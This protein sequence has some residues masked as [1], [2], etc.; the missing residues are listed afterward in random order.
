MLLFKKV[1]YELRQNKTK[2]ATK[3]VA[4]VLQK[5]FEPTVF[6][7]NLTISSQNLFNWLQR[8]IQLVFTSLR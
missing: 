8:Q 5:L 3:K 2:I 6:S 1:S 4:I 7:I